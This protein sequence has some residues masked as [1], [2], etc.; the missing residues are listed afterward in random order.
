M[1]VCVRLGDEMN[2]KRAYGSFTLIGIIVVR[3]YDPNF[4]VHFV[5]KVWVVMESV[6]ACV[7]SVCRGRV[8]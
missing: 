5:P 7:A 6:R 8:S 3:V 2:P 4:R 1:C